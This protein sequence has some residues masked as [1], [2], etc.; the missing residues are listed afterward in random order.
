M[1]TLFA[2]VA[3]P[4]Q[5]ERGGLEPMLIMKH[6]WLFKNLPLANINKTCMPH[7]CLELEVPTLQQQRKTKIINTNDINYCIKALQAILIMFLKWLRKPMT[8]A[9]ATQICQQARNQLSK[10]HAM[11]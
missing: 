7:S 5:S 4:A 10:A 3:E 1:P 8:K 6:P 9:Q 11:S 2:H